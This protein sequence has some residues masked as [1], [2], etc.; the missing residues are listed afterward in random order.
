MFHRAGVGKDAPGV[1]VRPR[2]IQSQQPS[3]SS[4]A[5]HLPAEW[6]LEANKEHGWHLH[7]VTHGSH[8][9]VH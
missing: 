4:R 2:R 7:Q 3:I 9:M 1:P 8:K 5:P 6:D